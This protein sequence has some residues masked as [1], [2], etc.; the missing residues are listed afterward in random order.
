M[1]NNF[2]TK[3]FLL[4]LVVGGIAAVLNW[5]AR[6]CLSIW[7]PFSSAVIIAYA[8]GMLT[9]FLLNHRLVFPKSN[10]K[11]WEQAR[12]FI[13]ANISLFP[14]VWFASI[15]I[16][17]WLKLMGIINYSE[18]LAHAFAIPMPMLVT[19]LF[20]KFFAFKEKSYE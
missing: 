7:L 1:I 3:Q 13:L 6:L 17:N 16:N 18:E 14:I 8:I 2:L 15:T 19:F 20:Y 9:A 12:D 10:K 5:L 11:T 4:F